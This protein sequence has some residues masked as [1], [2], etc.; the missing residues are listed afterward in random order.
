[1]CRTD[2][3]SIGRHVRG[4]WLSSPGLLMASCQL[5]KGWEV[6]FRGPVEESSHATLVW[7]LSLARISPH[8][9]FFFF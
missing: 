4:G 5:A 2:V 9:F 3:N 7:S 1:M 6:T 8:S